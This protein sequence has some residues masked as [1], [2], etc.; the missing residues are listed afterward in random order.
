MIIAYVLAAILI[1]TSILG[2]GAVSILICL[3]SILVINL[4]KQRLASTIQL[5]F[6]RIFKLALL[7]HTSAYLGLFIKALFIDGA[8]DLPAFIV[9]HL[10][11]HHVLCAL[12]AGTVTFLTLR[13]YAQT[14]QLASQQSTS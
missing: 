10:L 3:F 1:K 14:K 12:V 6:K 7:G 5:K 2:L 13:L 9:S 11:L 8:E 4:N